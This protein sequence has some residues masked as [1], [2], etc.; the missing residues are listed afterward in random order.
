M[1]EVGNREL[2]LTRGASM[3]SS[4]DEPVVQLP[5]HSTS[6]ASRGTALRLGQIQTVFSLGAPC[7][8]GASAFAIA[9][10]DRRSLGGGWSRVSVRRGTCTTDC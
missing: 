4:W 3:P 8:P 6:A 1:L 10:A 9:S 7:P 2:E 5:L